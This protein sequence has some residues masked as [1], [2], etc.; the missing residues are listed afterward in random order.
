MVD[1]V[2]A[3]K[4]AKVGI[5]PLLIIGSEDYLFIEAKDGRVLVRGLAEPI[6]LAV[7]TM[8][9]EPI[10]LVIFDLRNLHFDIWHAFLFV[11]EPLVDMPL[12]IL[13]VVLWI[14]GLGAEERA[15]DKDALRFPGFRV[16]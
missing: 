6:P 10:C 14:V 2:A 3:L 4:C 9:V 11:A 12:E 1:A 16:S 8:E 13:L 7:F 15:A 5:C